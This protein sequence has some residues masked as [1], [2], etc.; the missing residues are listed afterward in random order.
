MNQETQ[1][2]EYLKAG[3]S[4]TPIQALNKFGCFRLAA[5][6]YRLKERGWPVVCD[7]VNVGD[8]KFVGHYTLVNNKEL[9]P[10]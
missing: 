5:R 10:K 2:L 8:N 3:N 4:L 7:K 1:I 9:W 6:I